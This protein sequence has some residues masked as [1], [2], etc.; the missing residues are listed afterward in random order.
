MIAE[1]YLTILQHGGIVHITIFYPIWL[2]SCFKQ[3]LL[4]INFLFPFQ[5]ALFERWFYCSGK[6]LFMTMGLDLMPLLIPTIDSS[7]SQT[8][9]SLIVYIRHPMVGSTFAGLVC[10]TLYEK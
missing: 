9:L 5:T 7:E 6:N 10:G 3:P 1:L 4:K 8:M 2:Q